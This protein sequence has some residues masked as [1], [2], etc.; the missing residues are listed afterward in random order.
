MNLSLLAMS[1]INAGMFF[2]IAYYDTL[3]ENL[4]HVSL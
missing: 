2:V 1:I 4:L 3:V